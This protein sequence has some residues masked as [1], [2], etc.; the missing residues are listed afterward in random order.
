MIFNGIDGCKKGWFL[1]SLSENSY[2]YIL[3]D[4]LEKI[5]DRLN[6]AFLNL[7]DIP[8]GLE[9]KKPVRE[10][11]KIFK[12]ILGRKA[13]SIF[14]APVYP[15]LKCKTYQEACDLN[16]RITGKK[17]SLQTWFIIPKIRDA[18]SFLQKSKDKNILK[19]FHPETGF[20]ILN[21]NEHL[22]FKKR[23]KQ[24]IEERLSIL[25]KYL[26]AETIL[27]KICSETLRKDVAKDDILDAICCA[28]NGKFASKISA[29]PE[30]AEADSFGIKKE[31]LITEFIG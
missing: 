7:I 17:I 23:E 13:S 12:N 21:K 5:R 24:G 30:N 14:N 8:L 28:V 19:E 4:S 15:L 10:C 31:I 22:Q 16:H 3:T 20:M 26:D 9:D 18:N 27:D 6:N 2:S 29:V 25:G 11:D 1:F